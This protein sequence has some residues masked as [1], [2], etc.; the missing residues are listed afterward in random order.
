MSTTTADDDAFDA[1]MVQRTVPAASA[2]PLKL[3]PAVSP[4]TSWLKPGQ[5]PPQVPDEDDQGDQADQAASAPPPAPT[6]QPTQETPAMATHPRKK[7]A[8]KTAPKPARAERTKRTTT[9]TKTQATRVVAPHGAKSP[10]FRVCAEL[11]RA[12]GTLP[13]AELYERLAD[14]RKPQVFS[15]VFEAKKQGR[16][17]W[18]DA[19]GTFHLTAEGSTWVGS[20]APTPPTAP[21]KPARRQ[22]TTLAAAITAAP[23]STATALA[24]QR[25]EPVAERSFRCAVFSDGGFSVTKAGQQVELTQAETAEMLR[26][27]ERMAEQPA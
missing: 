17:Q 22:R 12:G 19:S 9:R 6:A 16:V 1:A 8:R 13:R 3:D 23:P 11:A 20:M 24:V 18:D 4:F 27:L 7:A 5:L 26:Y 14:L 2:P 21:D 25:F 15:A 10:Q